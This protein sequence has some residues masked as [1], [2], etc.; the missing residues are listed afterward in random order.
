MDTFELLKSKFKIIKSKG[1]IQ[2]VNNYNNGAGLTLEH[3]LDSTGG[4]FNIPDFLDIEIKSVFKYRHAEIDLF[5]S[6]PDGKI[7]PAGPWLSKNY[8]YPD[9]D[10]KNIN[11]FK[12]YVYGNKLNYIGYKYQFKIN[13]NYLLKRIELYIFENKN[14]INKDIYWDF[15]SLKEK[16]YRKDKKIAVFTFIKKNE[17]GKKFYKYDTLYMYNIK[18]FKRFLE[19]I[20]E[21]YI[22]INFKI[23]V[24][25]S[26]KYKGKFADHGTSFRI[27]L[28][29]MHK[30]FYKYY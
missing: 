28:N 7:F 18:N 21:G 25:K 3:E 19:L 15:D 26:G 23:G 5:N 29:N 24:H 2:S 22:F 16:L 30:L 11:V 20:E 9:K 8:G 12:G 10:Y 13:V 17:N 4:D 27:D 6:A 14:I 1:Y